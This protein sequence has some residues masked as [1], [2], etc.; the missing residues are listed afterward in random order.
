MR[1]L[2]FFLC[3]LLFLTASEKG[4]SQDGVNKVLVDSS[5]VDR[6]ES[7]IDSLELRF[8]MLLCDTLTQL[9]DS[10][11]NVLKTKKYDGLIQYMPTTAIL[12][13]HYDTLDKSY[14]QKLTLVKV[15]YVQNM[16]RKQHIKMLR[17]AKKHTYNL[18]TME[19]VKYRA[20]QSN[21]PEG[22]VHGEVLYLCKN[23]NKQ[24]YIRFVALQ[25]L[26]RWFIVD[27]LEIL[28]VN[29]I[30]SGGR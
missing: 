3:G 5:S 26:D 1:I 15:Q 12:S 2:S 24:F 4:W 18:R 7:E 25:I 23:G 29:P 10:I 14:L 11:F 8:N 27:E 28:E 20:K 6:H 19:L 13:E 9:A 17:Y 21:T 30:Q 22:H 16:L